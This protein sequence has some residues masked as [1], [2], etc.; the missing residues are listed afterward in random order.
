VRADRAGLV[1]RRAVITGIGIA[2]PLGDD[3]E[4][5]AENV[6]AGRVATAPIHAFDA[7]TFGA[8]VAAE[9]AISGDEVARLAAATGIDA[10]VLWI[11]R[12]TIFG[13]RA[14]RQ[15]TRSAFPEGA[16]PDLALSLGMGLEVLLLPDV[17]AC[18]DRTV[19]D[20]SIERLSQLGR[21]NAIRLSLDHVVRAVADAG[22]V[23]GRRHTI[24]SACASGTQAIAD[25]A[26]AIEHGARAVLAGATDSMVNPMGL[27][28]FSL[29]GALSPR[30]AS[31]A[32]RP[33]HRDRDGTVIGEGAAF[34]VL[35]ERESAR[36]RGA[37]IFAEVLGA[38]SSL[39]AHRVT[40]PHPNGDGARRAMEAALQHAGRPRL[41]YVN[42]HGTGT[43]ANDA[44]EVAAI[45]AVV[46][47]GEV[48]IGATK[49][50]IGHAM[51]AAGALELLATLL[52]FT[53]SRCAPTANLS[54]PDPACAADHVTS[55]RNFSADAALSNSFG[56]GGQNA[57]IILGAP[58]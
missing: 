55:A 22:S 7:R 28:C 9:A 11:D 16:P 48:P 23:T 8:T 10:S 53:H 43:P 30:G 37:R 24:L 52:C 36:A 38:G 33:F 18:Y 51:A 3:F 5:F 45:H 26:A 34:V 49:S 13:A 54:I 41:G 27:G 35:E 17:A 39:D 15:A 6:L 50:Q 29:L 44:I 46:G 1:S 47:G 42:A 4:T 32:C 58:R 31:D 19:R 2:S 12:K 21:K 14:A 57:S 20:L 56:F 25:G 40:A